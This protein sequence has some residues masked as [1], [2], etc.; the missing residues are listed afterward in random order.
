MGHYE[1]PLQEFGKRIRQLREEKGLSQRDLGSAFYLDN[2][3][4]S[5]IEHGKVNLTILTLLNLATALDVP[6]M[7][8]L[9]TMK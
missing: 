7:E 1:D 6:A 3:K 4:V 2:S 8:L 9:R 5:K